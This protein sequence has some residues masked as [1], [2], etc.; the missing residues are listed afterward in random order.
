MLAVVAVVA[1]VRQRSVLD[2]EV[3]AAVAQATPVQEVL[4]PEAVA[5]V[6]TELRQADQDLVAEQAQVLLS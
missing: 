3:Q 1:V 2:Q 6:A 5:A 4:I